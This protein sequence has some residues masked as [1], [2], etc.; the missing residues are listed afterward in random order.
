MRLRA[1]SAPEQRQAWDGFSLYRQALARYRKADL[2]A[3]QKEALKPVEK[4]GA[5]KAAE[6]KAAKAVE[7]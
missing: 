5:D 1:I 3:A 2:T 4:A 6:K 7:K